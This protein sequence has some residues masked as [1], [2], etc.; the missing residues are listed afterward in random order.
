MTI[1]TGP[2]VTSTQCGRCN[3]WWSTKA[4]KR[5][6][7]VVTMGEEVCTCP[8]PAP[9]RD[10]HL[11]VGGVSSCKIVKE[12]KRDGLAPPWR[13]LSPS[14]LVQDSGPRRVV[15][16]AARNGRGEPSL[17]TCDEQGRLVEL[18]ARHPLRARLEALPLL[19]EA[20]EQMEAFVPSSDPEAD[21]KEVKRIAE[22]NRRALRIAYAFDGDDG[23]DDA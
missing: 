18:P 16:T 2:V 10:V 8:E 9:P 14:T 23:A 13:W 4:G 22:L 21:E 12:K 3:G 7:H 5:V 6:P 19:L 15:L 17:K 1:K 11:D 20:C